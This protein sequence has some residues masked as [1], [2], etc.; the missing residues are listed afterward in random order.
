MRPYQE[1][2]PENDDFG[3]Q[4]MI[5]HQALGVELIQHQKQDCSIEVP[6]NLPDLV[7]NR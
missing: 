2:C 3:E 6:L 1:M 7:Q 5:D 4:Y